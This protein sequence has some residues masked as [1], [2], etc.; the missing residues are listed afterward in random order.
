MCAERT[1]C[2]HYWQCGGGGGYA[3]TI[4]GYT[5]EEK[6]K[7]SVRIQIFFQA[8]L[9]CLSYALLV[10]WYDYVSPAFGRPSLVCAM[11]LKKAKKTTF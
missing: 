4:L 7:L 3:R 9:V 10:I 11:L 2:S 5:G 1:R 8:A 6:G